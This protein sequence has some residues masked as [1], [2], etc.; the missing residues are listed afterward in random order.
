[1]VRELVIR[2]SEEDSQAIARAAESDLPQV[3]FVRHEN[4]AR[5]RLVEQYHPADVAEELV[6][7]AKKYL[8][9][10]YP[11]MGDALADTV[12]R[13]REYSAAP[14]DPR[15]SH[16]VALAC[17]DVL[18]SVL[19][20]DVP[21]KT[22]RDRVPEHEVEERL[23]LAEWLYEI[24]QRAQ[25]HFVDSGE[26]EAAEKAALEENSENVVRFMKKATA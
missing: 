21:G 6:D 8:T 16:T 23:K 13:W 5:D 20:Y 19:K 10:P 11:W 17:F 2:Q 3:S 14:T 1:M 15:Y 18:R 9:Y 25:D 4:E 22:L 7:L 24:A 26:A 12:A